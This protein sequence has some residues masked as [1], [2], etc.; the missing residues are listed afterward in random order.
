MSSKKNVLHIEREI[1]PVEPTIIKST[2]TFSF[3]SNGSGGLDL[4]AKGSDKETWYLLE[5]ASDGI[6]TKYSSIPEELGFNLDEEGALII[7]D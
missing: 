3:E 6:V 5:F 4:I 7:S 2:V 1:V